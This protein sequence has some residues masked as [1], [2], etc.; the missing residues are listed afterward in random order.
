MEEIER[1]YYKSLL[2]RLEQVRDVYLFCCFTGLA[3]TD[4]MQLTA[5]NIITGIGGEEWIITERQKTGALEEV[6]LLPLALEIL[7][8]YRCNAVLQNKNQLPP[9]CSN[10]RFNGYQNKQMVY[11]IAFMCHTSKVV[12]NGSEL[13]KNYSATRIQEQLGIKGL[14]ERKQKLLD[15]KRLSAFAKG[16]PTQ[17][18]AANLL[19]Y[20]YG[21]GFKLEALKGKFQDTNYFLFFQDENKITSIGLYGSIRAY[22]EERNITP[23]LCAHLNDHVKDYGINLIQEYIH[24]LFTQ[25]SETLFGHITPDK[26]QKERKLNW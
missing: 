4:V 22:F 14:Q 8:K 21:N 10:Q 25:Q 17:G 6:P 16:I 7:E 20:I 5:N 12:V 13:G 18:N 15:Q 1:I 11:G 24:G 9:L 3:F 26:K 23:E 2:P 19:F